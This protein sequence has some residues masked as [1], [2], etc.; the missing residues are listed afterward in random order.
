MKIDSADLRSYSFNNFAVFIIDPVQIVLFNLSL[1]IN[2]R[3]FSD[4]PHFISF[5]PFTSVPNF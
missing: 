4:S 3:L 5:L 1:F 2:Y